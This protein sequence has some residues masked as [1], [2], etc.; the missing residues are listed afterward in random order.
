MIPCMTKL[1]NIIDKSNFPGPVLVL[2]LVLLISQQ[3]VMRIPILVIPWTW[4]EIN[5]KK[6]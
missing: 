4:Q 6:W 3:M 5:Y 1:L 2:T